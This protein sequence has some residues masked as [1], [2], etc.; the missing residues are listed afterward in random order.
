VLLSPKKRNSVEA[1]ARAE[2][3]AGRRL[4]LA[5]GNHPMLDANALA[6]QPVG[7]PA[8]SPAA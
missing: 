5:F 3:V 4:A 2:H 8:M 7:P 6:G 1:L